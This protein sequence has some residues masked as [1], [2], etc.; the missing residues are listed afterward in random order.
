MSVIAESNRTDWS[1]C[2]EHDSCNP[3]RWR[4]WA[5]QTIRAISDEGNLLRSE[6]EHACDML[7]Q[8]ADYLDVQYD[9]GFDGIALVPREG[10]V[11]TY[12]R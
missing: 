4:E 8:V 9:G 5:E 3:I 10:F 2:D 6:R 12:D 11:L 7:L 1:K